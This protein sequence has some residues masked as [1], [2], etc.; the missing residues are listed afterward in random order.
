MVCRPRSIVNIIYLSNRSPNSKSI[1][2]LTTTLQLRKN[3]PYLLTIP[4]QT[5]TIENNQYLFGRFPKS[6][7]FS[8]QLFKKGISMEKSLNVI[9]TVD[10]AADLLRIP[11]STVYKLAQL[12]KIPT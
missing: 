7:G 5:A 3:R 9:L 8:T 12:G 6:G 4:K 1:L 11:R 2:F 10:E